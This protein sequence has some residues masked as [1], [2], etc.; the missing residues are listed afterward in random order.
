MDRPWMLLLTGLMAV[1][2]AAQEVTV[3][4][5]GAPDPN[6]GPPGSPP[7]EMEGRTI[8]H[9]PL[10]DFG[11][12]EGW[13]VE[14]HDAEGWLYLSREQRVFGETSGKLV[15][16]AL[17]DDPWL[18]VRP[19]EPIP[20][21]EPWD[22]VDLWNYG[23]NWGWAPDPSTPQVGISVVVE[24]ATGV[25][26]DVALGRVDYEYWFL[27]HGRRSQSMNGPSSFVGFRITN[28][29]NAEP[30][31][32]YFGPCSL[33]QEVLGPLSFEPWPSQLPFPTRSETILPA[34][35]E[36]GIRN[37]VSREG[38]AVVFEYQGPDT[39][40]AY[41]WRPQEGGLGDITLE[42]QGRIIRPCAGGGPVLASPEGGFGPGDDLVV[43]RLLERRIENDTLICRWEHSRGRARAQV[44]YRIRIQAKSLIVEME[45]DTGSIERV[46]LGRAQG[47]TDPTLIRVPYLTYGGNDPRVLEDEGL[48][49]FEQLD[50]YFS[51][52]SSLY[53][54]A[55]L[56]TDWASF[57]GGAV[58]T[59]RTD[60][61]RNPVRERLFLNAS[62]E[63]DEVLPI[64]P[65]PPSP[66]RG[67]MAHRLWRVK[68]DADHEAEVAEARAL[69]ARG[70]EHIAIRY[71]EDSWR[72]GGE[73]FTFRTS[74]GPARG[75]D[76]AL[77]SVVDRVKSLGWLVGLYTNY[78]DFAPV[79]SYWDPDHVSRDPDG[80]WQRAWMRCYAPKPLWAVEMEAQLA[81]I[82]DKKFDPNH[83]YCDVH[84]AVTPFQRVDYD[85]RVPRAGTFR[86]VF[87][88]FGRLL[89][90][91][92]HAYDGPVY[93]EGNNHWWYAGL[94]DGN[95]AQIVSGAP[96]QEPLLV[97]FDL[98]R[99][100]PLQMDAGM[101]APG[102]FFRGA[103][104]DL[105]QFI[106]TTVA[107][108]HIGFADWHDMAGLMKL[109]YMHQPIQESYV[110]VPVARIGYEVDGELLPTSRVLA[111]DSARRNRVHVVY[112]NGFEVW[113]NGEDEEWRVGDAV[114]PR[115]G[116]LAR[117]D[118]AAASTVLLPQDALGGEGTA[119][120]VK[121]SEAWREGSSYYADS[122]DGFALTEKLG[123]EGAGALKRE[124]DG[125]YAY[126]ATAFRDLAFE[127]GLIGLRD[128]ES[129]AATALGLDG[130]ELTAPEIRW[131]RGRIHI[132]PRD[133]DAVRYRLE[134]IE[135][136]PVLALEAGMIAPTGAA[137]SV[138][139]KRPWAEPTARWEWG[140]ESR[141]VAAQIRGGVASVIVPTEVPSG[142]HLW[143]RV[144]DDGEVGWIDFIALPAIVVEARLESAESLRRG[145]S[146]S[147]P[148][149]VRSYLPAEAEVSLEVVAP[150]ATEAALAHRSLT[151]PAGGVAETTLRIGLPWGAAEHVVEL[152]AETPGGI[153]TSTSVGLVAAFSRV[154]VAKLLEMP[155]GRGH[156]RRGGDEIQGYGSITDGCFDVTTAAAGGEARRCFFSHPPYEGGT[157]YSWAT[158]VVDL[159]AGSPAQLEF[160]MGMRDGLDAT[161]GVTFTVEVIDASGKAARVFSE[162]YGDTA[163]RPAT[164]DLAAFAGQ[165]VV[166]KLIA[167][168][169]PADN[170][171][172]DHALWGEP[173]VVTAEPVLEVRLAEQE[174]GLLG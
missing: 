146:L 81:P 113:A 84:T 29:R 16:R 145:D 73:S 143:L 123:V 98:L 102:M 111:S 24:D 141:S 27:M 93:S 62:P 6:P 173:C 34:N 100:H 26:S 8:A 11:S 149:T 94:T 142:A 87:E 43:T 116:L 31:T 136:E 48:F 125:W 28:A 168:A 19:P 167:D 69:R 25:Q 157:G 60:G 65:N 114:L 112:A 44:T 15:Y 129:V 117:G 41:R 107:Y 106:A 10:V 108:G 78:T 7:Y 135:S 101:G 109:Y 89:Y 14:G 63:F 152:S 130:T 158:F 56:G 95:Y 91:E 35:H 119:P 118:G 50:W 169:G 2:A 115:W 3:H 134:P 161:D 105:D 159:P 148:I 39:R 9:D 67:M 156:A 103:P 86:Q 70:L 36:S 150:G 74:A 82:I 124:T 153:R 71:H 23:N 13:I 162:H 5:A 172:A 22:S 66:M 46:A 4:P 59:P 47:L 45:S 127:P 90:N 83:S 33:Y 55:E 40:L 164:V 155:Y 20:I 57:N 30:R 72:D 52:A 154:T 122:P 110:M 1:S 128:G 121:V 68:H 49:L 76:P 104:P 80:S 51:D 163:W 170:T 17:G 166:I 38:S 85:H 96:S 88:C 54:G 138:S 97:D 64:I 137:V 18:L 92:K 77:R 12:V 174:A 126:P 151:V 21:P 42:Y 140:G 147:L 58:Y 61:T 79:N 99:M 32:L 53:G 120:R 139:R 75:G 131:S 133:V 165:R 144:E 160:S 37:I 132:L 171:T